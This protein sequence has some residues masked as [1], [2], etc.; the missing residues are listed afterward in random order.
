MTSFSITQES[1]DL[2][3]ERWL[4]LLPESAHNTAFL[5]PTWQRLW[6]NKFGDGYELLLFS[7]QTNSTLDA[8]APLKKKDGQIS[9]VGSPDVCDYMDFIVRKGHEEGVY[10][11]L[12][13][14]L[15]KLDWETL[16]LSSVAGHSPTYK[17]LPDLLREEGLNVEVRAEDVCPASELPSTWDEY[18]SGL[19]KKDRHELRRKI[20]R[21]YSLADA[22]Y[23]VVQD[24]ETFSSDLEDFL[25]L[26][27]KSRVDK[28]QFM[29]PEIREFFH[30]AL[31]QM[32]IEG[33]VK[34]AFLELDG[35]RVSSAV[36]FDYAN[37]FLLYNSGYD[38]EYS[39]LSVGLLLKAFCLKDA[40]ESKKICFDFLKGAESYKYRLGAEDMPVYSIYASR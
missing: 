36:C 20:R 40:I 5:T 4:T 9:F 34:L 21:L 31:S 8:V 11:S 39:S 10:S 2:L 1:F 26:A 30:T 18:L 25:S 19:R 29:T 24:P 28:A 16:S 7:F 38:V 3:S 12:I 22:R 33:Y 32:A 23:Y 17:Y 37:S 35:K 15:K 6:W 27:V 14:H 13:D